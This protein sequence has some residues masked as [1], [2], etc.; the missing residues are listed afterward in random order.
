MTIPAHSWS[1]TPDP[2]SDE[3]VT[4]L[5][6]GATEPGD[7]EVWLSLKG[8]SLVVESTDPSEGMVTLS[9]VEGPDMNTMSVLLTP[10][11]T[12]ELITDAIRRLVLIGGP[13]AAVEAVTAADTDPDEVCPGA[14]T[15]VP[16]WAPM[17]SRGLLWG[18]TGE[19]E[20]R[21]DS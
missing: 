2:D 6:V 14:D 3:P 5:A 17:D 13:R 1:N 9:V 18:N 20:L 19:A 21:Y 16:P 12:G 10:E 7:G 11:Q 8:T 4:T 15:P